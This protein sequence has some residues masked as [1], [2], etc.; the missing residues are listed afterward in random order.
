LPDACPHC[1][2]DIQEED[3]VAE[4]FQTD[5]PTKPVHRKFHIHKGCCKSC[6]RSVRGRHPL[7]TSDAV[8]AAQSQTGPNAQAS[9]VYLNK[10][11][12]MSYGKIADYFREANGI[13][14]R[15]ST[16]TRIVLRVARKLQPTYQE[17]K[18][19][20]KL[21]FC[22]FPMPCA[23]RSL[24]ELIFRVEERVGN[25]HV[26]GVGPGYALAAMYSSSQSRLSWQVDFDALLTN[27]LA[28]TLNRSRPALS[29]C[30]GSR[31]AG[32]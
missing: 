14:L 18:D 2:G 12:G 30:R 26:G 9:I 23:H 27:P 7:Q 22:T 31:F 16:A 21:A 20:L 32:V 28:V 1:G 19:S 29:R 10:R 3:D 4:Q 24:T 17:I 6:G 11:A 8:G 13:R 25:R 15:P 5:I